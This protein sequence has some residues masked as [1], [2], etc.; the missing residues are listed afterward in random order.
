MKNRK[1]SRNFQYN[2]IT[3]EELS[4]LLFVGFGQFHGSEWD[5]L[6]EHDLEALAER[7]SSPSAGGLQMLDAFIVVFNVN[8]LEK[9]IY[10]YI[11]SEHKLN[12]VNNHITEDELI[13]MLTDQYWA[14]GLAAGIF[15]TADMQRMWIKDPGH[16]GYLCA[17]LESGHVSQTLLLSATALKHQTF[18]TGAFRDDI[19][20]QKFNLP[21]SMF[22][23]FFIGLGH[24]INKAVPEQILKYLND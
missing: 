21:D 24:G 15:I 14:E 20:S 2:E 16:K 1:T 13:Y 10:Q 11:P 5:E 12:L 9:G 19:V 17:Y 18:I 22:S 6:N 8:G 4:T 3:L 7:R 23:T